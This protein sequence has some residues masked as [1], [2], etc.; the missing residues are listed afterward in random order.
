MHHLKQKSKA[1]FTENVAM[2][3]QARVAKSEGVSKLNPIDPQ[4]K[5]GT[6]VRKAQKVLF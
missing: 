5:A 3:Q 6:I 4:G 1:M 2:Y